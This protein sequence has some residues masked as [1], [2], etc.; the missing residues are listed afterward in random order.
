MSISGLNWRYQTRSARE[1]ARLPI[2]AATLIFVLL[3]LGLWSAIWRAV[4]ILAAAS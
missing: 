2:P 1:A 3:S 4:T